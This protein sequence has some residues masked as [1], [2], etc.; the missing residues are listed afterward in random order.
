MTDDSK[1]KAATY[2]LLRPFNDNTF[3]MFSKSTLAVEAC[4]MVVKRPV[5]TFNCTGSQIYQ[6]SRLNQGR[7]T[8]ISPARASHNRRTVYKD[9][10]LVKDF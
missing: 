3:D 5:R 4:N 10:A 8:C 9:H 6:A 2:F 1:M 7:K